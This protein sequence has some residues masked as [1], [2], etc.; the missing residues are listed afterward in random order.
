V[1]L[2]EQA[3]IQQLGEAA[4]GPGTW[5]FSRRPRSHRFSFPAAHGR[6]RPIVGSAAFFASRASIYKIGQK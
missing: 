5:R 3:N 4:Q 2:T 1:L 6:M